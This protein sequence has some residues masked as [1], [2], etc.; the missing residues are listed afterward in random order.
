MLFV[1]L[2]LLGLAKGLVEVVV[3]LGIV[4]STLGRKLG[5]VE[6]VGGVKEGELGE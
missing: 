5:A 6:G 4:R 3:L 2:A 1:A